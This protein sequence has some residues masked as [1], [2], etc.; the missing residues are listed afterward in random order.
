M[1]CPPKHKRKG[2]LPVGLGWS[3]QPQG[4]AC[5]WDHQ[6]RASELAG[7]EVMALPVWWLLSRSMDEA[8]RHHSGAGS[9]A[10]G[11]ILVTA[12]AA[13]WTHLLCCEILCCSTVPVSEVPRIESK[14]PS[15]RSDFKQASGYR[16]RGS[17]LLLPA[18]TLHFMCKPT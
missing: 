12:P 16:A 18:N 11:L 10:P 17:W 1:L 4:L 15:Y 13:A 2:C 3:Q 8:G 5:R 7:T 9:K 14:I 6:N